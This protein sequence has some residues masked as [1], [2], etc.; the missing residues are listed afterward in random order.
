M[1]K[2]TDEVNKN[3][4]VVGGTNSER[5]LVFVILQHNCRKPSMLCV[6]C[7]LLKHDSWRSFGTKPWE[8]DQYTDTYLDLHDCGM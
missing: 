2:E 5:R 4:T 1:K 8:L 3:E 6:L 7:P